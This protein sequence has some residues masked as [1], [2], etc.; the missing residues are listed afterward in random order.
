MEEKKST[1]KL[2]SKISLYTIKSI[3]RYSKIEKYGKFDKNSSSK[4]VIPI[5]EDKTNP[6]EKFDLKEKDS[7]DEKLKLLLKKYEENLPRYRI[8]IFNKILKKFGF[9][10]KI[11][12]TGISILAWVLPKGLRYNSRFVFIYHA[13]IMALIN[14]MDKYMLDNCRLIFQYLDDPL[15]SYTDL[16]FQKDPKNSD[17]ISIKNSNADEYESA[18]NSIVNIFNSEVSNYTLIGILERTIK[19]IEK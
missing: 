4:N 9:K 13:L 18:T 8:K 11:E 2:F 15:I 5:K 1:I 16:S 3:N 17:R 6:N 19:S 14:N 7:N 10:T 12:K